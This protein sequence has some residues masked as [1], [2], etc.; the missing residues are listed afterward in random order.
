MTADALFAVAAPPQRRP[1]GEA[2]AVSSAV[3]V[4]FACLFQAGIATQIGGAA[5]VVAG[6]MI[7]TAAVTDFKWCRIFNWTTYLAFGWAVLFGVV[8][9]MYGDTPIYRGAEVVPLADAVGVGGLGTVLLGFGI[10]FAMMFSL[11]AVFGGGA[12]DVKYIAALGALAGWEAGIYTWVY[13]CLAA[14]VFVVGVIVV[15]IGPR[16]IL[17]EILLKLG[18]FNLSLLIGGPSAETRKLFSRRIPMAPFF[19]VGSAFALSQ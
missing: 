9:E 12:G 7:A 3:L 2:L 4:A 13:G 11:F 8:V 16:A 10:C 15:R 6:L 5:K 1:W 19:A 14:S 17:A 18:L